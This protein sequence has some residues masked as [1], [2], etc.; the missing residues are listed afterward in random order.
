[1][2]PRGSGYLAALV[3]AAVLVL[4]AAGKLA[5]PAATAAAF[6][7]LRV[8]RPGAAARVVPVAE[9]AVA[10]LLIAAP[11]AGGVAAFV[12]LGVFSAL[13][14]RVLRAGIRAPCRCFGGV[15]E[16]PVSAPDVFRNALLAGLALTAAAATG[17]RSPSAG[18][19]VLVAAAV[20]AGL[21][22]LRL[23]RDHG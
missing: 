23:A 18:A 17:P 19:F 13:L 20:G 15:R 11:R 16:A 4:A 10:V 8:P 2:L 14:V 12:L 3:L 22:A 21:A 7:T 1:M 5:R 6:R 9:L